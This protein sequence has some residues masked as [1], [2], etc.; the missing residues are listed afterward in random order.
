MIDIQIIRDNPEMVAEKSRQKGYDVDITQLLGF[1]TER[2]EL[3][4]QVEELRRQR[5]EHA[6]M[7]KDTKGTTSQ[8][9]IEKGKDLKLQL[10][11]LEHQLDAIDKEFQTLLNRV[12]NLSFDD[13]PV[14]GEEDSVEIKQWGEQPT[15]ARDHLDIAEQKDWID[16]ER[17]AKVAGAKFY[18]LKGDL[19]L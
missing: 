3:Q 2:R 12:P 5:N 11:N 10:S 16:F 19:A 18:F 6:A 1:D 7:F 9:N 17:G 14:G 8:E 15:G 13:V 4:G